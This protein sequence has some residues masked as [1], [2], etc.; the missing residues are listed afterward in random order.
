VPVLRRILPVLFQ[1]RS[2]GAEPRAL[3][4]S[5]SGW[6][7]RR[8]SEIVNSTSRPLFAQVN[9]G[10]PLPNPWR[11]GRSDLTDAYMRIG[12]RWRMWLSPE[13]RAQRLRKE[14]IGKSTKPRTG[15]DER[16]R[17]CTPRDTGGTLPCT[18]SE[19]TGTPSSA[20]VTLP[21]CNCG[22]VGSRRLRNDQPRSDPDFRQDR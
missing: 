13:C 16:Q 3:V 8:Y 10:E 21:D 15:T 6:P 18:V 7:S 17:T 11:Q 2:F 22:S 9:S 19:C 5:A 1:F 20:A 12:H 14:G 4:N